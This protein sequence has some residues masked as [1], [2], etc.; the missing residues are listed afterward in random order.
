MDLEARIAELDE[1]LRQARADSSHS[2]SVSLPSH[3]ENVFASPLPTQPVPA[4]HWSPAKPT[5]YVDPAPNSPWR[6]VGTRT[7]KGGDDEIAKLLQHHRTRAHIMDTRVE[8]THEKLRGTNNAIVLNDKALIQT[9]RKR[10]IADAETTRVLE[11]AER[12]LITLEGD[13]KDLR[14]RTGDVG[15][16]R[17]LL[18]K[19]LDEVRNATRRA[20]A[21]LVELKGE[22]S[23]LQMRLQ[24]GLTA[25]QEHSKR[26]QAQITSFSSTKQKLERRIAE[27]T[28]DNK[29][30]SERLRKIEAQAN[31]EASDWHNQQK[32]FEKDIAAAEAQLR[33]AALRL[34]VAEQDLRERE[35]EAEIQRKHRDRLQSDLL[36]RRAS[37]RQV[38][39]TR[40]LAEA[41]EREVAVRQERED[42]LAFLKQQL[43]DICLQVERKRQLRDAHHDNVQTMKRQIT[44]LEFSIRE[45]NKVSD[46]CAEVEE[47]VH[48]LE[49][50][51]E[52]RRNEIGQ[53]QLRMAAAGDELHHYRRQSKVLKERLEEETRLKQ[54][55]AEVT[56]ELTEAELV[57]SE[58]LA[59]LERQEKEAL[60]EQSAMQKELDANSAEVDRAHRDATIELEALSRKI[61]HVRQQALDKEAELSMLQGENAM[62][63]AT[64]AQLEEERHKLEREQL[65]RK[66]SAA[67]A[68][69][70]ALS[71]LA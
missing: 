10:E 55:I 57:H 42:A 52:D 66:Q 59:S 23:T 33:D 61:S 11:D 35:S 34:E 40:I 44:S 37:E 43:D 53:L 14:R 28:E 39:M 63:Q 60:S 64:I 71:E 18:L 62:K 22:E 1:R 12:R 45:K 15:L 48:S 3:R 67:Q 21:R 4:A 24:E 58:E 68:A 17:E 27:L 19:Q 25:V 51:L 7:L 30:Q 29:A 47:S 8:D 16:E 54:Q 38:E 69:R 36:D 26:N 50:Q 6:D 70:A 2:G 49:R 31:T 5:A 56:R 46:E 41:E 65:Q 13:T 20:D 32:K 9:T